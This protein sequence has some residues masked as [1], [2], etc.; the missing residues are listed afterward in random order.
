MM[1]PGMGISSPL[2]PRGYPVPSHF[3]WWLRVIS[4][5]IWRK[6]SSPRSFFRQPD[7]LR[8]VQGVPFHLLELHRGQ[9]ARFEKDLVGHSHLA[10]VVE[11]G[12]PE[13]EIDR[14]VIQVVTEAGM[15]LQA[16]GQ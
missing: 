4:S 6:D 7:R 10:D 15:V 12:E 2:R 5:A 11:R 13:E 9:L 1:R 16:I 3:S 8:A 14:G